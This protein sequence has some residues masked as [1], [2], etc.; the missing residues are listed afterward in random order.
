LLVN[1]TCHLK[2]CDFGMARRMGTT[3]EEHSGYMTAY[4]KNNNGYFLRVV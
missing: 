4:V 3:P 2:I 1:S